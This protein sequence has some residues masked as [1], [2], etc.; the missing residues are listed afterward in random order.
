MRCV[1]CTHNTLHIYLDREYRPFSYEMS[2]AHSMLLN[3]RAVLS[4][5][6]HTYTGCMGSSVHV[7]DSSKNINKNKN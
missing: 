6:K 7:L 3:V 1:D 2:Q 4:A 5:H